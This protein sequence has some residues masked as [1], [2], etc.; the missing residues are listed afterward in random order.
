MEAKVAEKGK[1]LIAYQKRLHALENQGK[2]ITPTTDVLDE[3]HLIEEVSNEKPKPHRPRPRTAPRLSLSSHKARRT[4]LSLDLGNATAHLHDDRETED[5]SSKKQLGSGDN[6]IQDILEHSTPGIT[7]SNTR[8]SEYAELAERCTRSPDA[9]PDTWKQS[10]EGDIISESSMSLVFSG[11][12]GLTTGQSPPNV[13]NGLDEETLPEDSKWSD[14]HSE[15]TAENTPI[16]ELADERD[17]EQSLIPGY[18]YVDDVGVLRSNDFQTKSAR[19]YRSRSTNDE[20]HGE[21]MGKMSGREPE[22]ESESDACGRLGYREKIKGANNVEQHSSD[23]KCDKEI[24][25]ARSPRMGK[26]NVLISTS[27]GQES[28]SHRES[29][30]DRNIHSSISLGNE[31][32]V[33]GTVSRRKTTGMPHFSLPVLHRRSPKPGYTLQSL[34]Y[35]GTHKDEDDALVTGRKGRAGAKLA[36][37]V[38]ESPIQ[39][40]S[41]RTDVLGKADILRIEDEREDGSTMT[42][43]F[44]DSL[45]PCAVDATTSANSHQQLEEHVPYTIRSTRS[46]RSNQDLH[47]ACEMQ[48]ANDSNQFDVTHFHEHACVNAT[49]DT[50]DTDRAKRQKQ[51]EITSPSTAR[52]FKARQSESYFL[53]IGDIS[54][55]GVLPSDMAVLT[56]KR[57]KRDKPSRIPVL[58]QNLP[59]AGNSDLVRYHHER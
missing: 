19:G 16:Q 38:M 49:S 13:S 23:C 26:D 55:T 32:T 33:K 30:Q 37:S 7:A 40:T 10:Q 54:P 31:T 36:R 39:R 44:Y 52:I 45:E 59:N 12:L 14:H 53:T 20:G 15:G 11:E 27:L 2:D 5:S 22:Q 1:Q 58:G 34:Q 9:T 57:Q 28:S 56:T 4:D 6:T 41:Y 35:E 3:L 47:H 18:S 48:A 25:T 29:N 42:S 51:P 17:P 21:D 8:G 50:D 46:P 24:L 43:A